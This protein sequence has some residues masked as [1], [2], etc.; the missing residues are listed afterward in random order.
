[1]HRKETIRGNQ[2]PT[3]S[4]RKGVGQ[5]ANA[6]PGQFQT[7]EQVLP[8]RIPRRH[9]SPIGQTAM[10]PR[11]YYSS[12]DLL[13]RI[14][15]M[16]PN[17]QVEI[18]RELNLSR[19]RIT[20]LFKMEETRARNIFTRA[21]NKGQIIRPPICSRCFKDCTPE[22]HHPDYSKPLEVVWLCYRCHREEHKR[23]F[24]DKRGPRLNRRARVLEKINNI[25]ATKEDK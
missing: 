17:S 1:M 24:K 9:Q 13:A 16:Q 25:A 19:S 6:E 14:S 12:D 7:Q 20:Q 11:K 15:Q 23:L 18:A 2:F 3:R 5:T 21:L 8:A 10:T 22:G 4:I